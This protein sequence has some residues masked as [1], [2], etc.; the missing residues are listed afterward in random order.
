MFSIWI[1]FNNVIN[2]CDAKLNFQH[3]YSSL[4]KWSFRNHSN[5]LICCSRN[6]NIIVKLKKM[7]QKHLL[8][9]KFV[10]LSLPEQIHYSATYSTLLPFAVLIMTHR[11]WRSFLMCAFDISLRI[12]VRF[13]HYA[14]IKVSNLKYLKLNCNL[15]LLIQTGSFDPHLLVLLAYALALADYFPEEVVREIFNV[16][17]LA[18]LDAHLE[19]MSLCIHMKL[20][21]IV[22]PKMKIW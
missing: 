12:L 8:L 6:M 5:M 15:F 10:C 11:R 3:H 20:K 13:F 9:N 21:G 16:D 2:S 7:H 18:K 22:H 19:S 17:F 1:Y 14:F 4:V